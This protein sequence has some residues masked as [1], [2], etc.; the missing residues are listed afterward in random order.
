MDHIVTIYGEIIITIIIGIH[1]LRG[2]HSNRNG[3]HNNR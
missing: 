2:R 3:D 1:Y